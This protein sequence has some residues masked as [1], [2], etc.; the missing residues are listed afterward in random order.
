MLCVYVTALILRNACSSPS[1]A[2]SYVHAIC[3]QLV[4][5]CNL[6]YLCITLGVLWN[7]FVS[8][9]EER[10]VGM[11]HGEVECGNKDINEP[12]VAYVINI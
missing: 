9:K 4:R 6:M 2:M 1:L 10:S 5:L 8:A 3:V 11:G 12:G 7:N